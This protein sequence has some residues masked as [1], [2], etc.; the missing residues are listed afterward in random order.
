M[1]VAA[2]EGPL[3]GF[4]GPLIAILERHQLAPQVGQA[5]EAARG[6]QF[7]LNDRE[8]DLKLVEPTGV[9]RG[10][11]QNDV[12]PLGVQA[13]GGPSATVARTVVGD[14]EHPAC[15]PIGF[16]ARDLS[17][18]AMEG[19]NGVLALAATEQPGPMDV[20]CDDIGQ[21]TSTHI[22]MLDVDR[23]AWRRRQ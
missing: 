16:S 14:Q 19:R 2:C 23:A 17:D 20:P 15:R 10:V 8:V 18:Q 5:V 1:Q 12:G 6:Q 22:F 3:E 7:P 13:I 4:G 11:N 9:N 21:H